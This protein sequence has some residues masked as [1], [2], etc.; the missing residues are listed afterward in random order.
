VAEVRGQFPGRPFG[1]VLEIPEIGRVFLGELLLDDNTYRVIGMRLEL[2]CSTHGSLSVSTASK[3]G[4][5][6][7]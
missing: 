2:G 6:I 5:G 3:E 4:T 1:H 7:P